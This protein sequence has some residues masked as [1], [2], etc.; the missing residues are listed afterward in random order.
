MQ[1][2]KNTDEKL[3]CIVNDWMEIKEENTTL[4]KLLKEYDD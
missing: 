4:K 1:H 2:Q 3:E